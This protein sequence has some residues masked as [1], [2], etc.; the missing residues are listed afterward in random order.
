MKAEVAQQISLLELTEID[1]ELSRL[2]HQSAHLPE[3]QRL[4]Q[5]VAHG[6]GG[7][8]AGHRV[9]ED[10]ADLLAPQGLKFAARQARQFGAVQAQ[11]AAFDVARR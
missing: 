2:A 1:A 11:A 5:L 7:V 3:Q 6:V 10:H 4:E 8:E 9:L